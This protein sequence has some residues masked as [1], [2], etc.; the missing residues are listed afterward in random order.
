MVET[1]IGAVIALLCVI[2]GYGLGQNGDRR[3]RQPVEA[4][5]KSTVIR[6]ESDVAE[7][8]ETSWD[9]IRGSVPRQRDGG[10][11]DPGRGS[12]EAEPH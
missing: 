1:I 6:R 7:C 5:R 8:G 9:V 12:S 11:D 3:E 10:F 2:A 4:S